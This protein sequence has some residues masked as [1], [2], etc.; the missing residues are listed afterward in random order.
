M[1]LR[2]EYY[3]FSGKAWLHDSEDDVYLGGMFFVDELKTVADRYHK[4]DSYSRMKMRDLE[5]KYNKDSGD[6][7]RRIKALYGQPIQE[8]R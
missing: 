2:E 7:L 3:E 1:S 6:A 5:L 4:Q 8:R